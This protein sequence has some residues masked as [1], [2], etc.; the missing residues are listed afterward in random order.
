MRS[1]SRAEAGKW[2]HSWYDLTALHGTPT[3]LTFAAGP[4][5]QSDS[6]GSD[7]QIADSV[8]D[9]LRRA[10]RRPRG[11]NPTACRSPRWQDDPYARGSYAYMT[12]GSTTARSRR[13][14]HTDRR[15]AAPRRRGHLDRRP[16]D[17]DRC[18]EVGPSGG[19]TD[20]GSRGVVHGD[21]ELIRRWKKAAPDFSETASELV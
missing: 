11:R 10:V 19:R 17:G 9:A 14:G 5:R 18:A 6:R 21:L 16:G 7:T 20:P 15:C 12:V 4:V 8:L 2:W 1:A 13:P 3:L